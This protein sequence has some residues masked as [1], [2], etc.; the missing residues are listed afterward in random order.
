MRQVHSPEI[1]LRA[2]VGD[3]HRIQ[4][5]SAN[6]QVERHVIC[7]YCRLQE[8]RAWHSA[9]RKVC[10][11]LIGVLMTM[12]FIYI[13][14]QLPNWER[15]GRGYGRSGLRDVYYHTLSATVS[16]HLGWGAQI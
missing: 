14:V 2:Q 6:G 15:R 8:G 5:Y 13:L 3:I 10:D 16:T 7:R 9:L 1:L 4:V 11:L 12:V